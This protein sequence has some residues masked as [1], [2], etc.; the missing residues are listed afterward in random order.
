MNAML[1]DNHVIWE[2]TNEKQC[3]QTV[4]VSNFKFC[5]IKESKDRLRMQITAN[6]Q[7][8]IKIF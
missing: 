1:G 5:L 7:A 2:Q 8:K 4:G 3:Q 6:Y